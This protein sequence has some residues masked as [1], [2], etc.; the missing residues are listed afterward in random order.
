[1]GLLFGS[2]RYHE[3]DSAIVGIAYVDLL[4]DILEEHQARVREMGVDGIVSGA[5][6]SKLIPTMD[7]VLDR[8]TGYEAPAQA[9]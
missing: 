4:A 1:M 9:A 2:V 5:Q 3:R 7:R 6:L 8:V